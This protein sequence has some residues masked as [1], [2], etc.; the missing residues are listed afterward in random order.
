MTQTMTCPP[1]PRRRPG[2]LTFEAFL[3]MDEPE[4]AEWVDGRL[5]EMPGVTLEHAETTR[6][7][8]GLM[9]GLAEREEAGQVHADPFLMKLPDGRPGR[10]PDIIFIAR[11]HLDRLM[12]NHLA[13]PADVAVEVIS[14]GSRTIDRG[15]KYYEYEAGGVSEYWL[16]D[17]ERLVAEFYRLD[18]NGRYQP[19]ATPGGIF[20][21]EA[22]P[23]FW[24]RVEWLWTRPPLRLVE[25]ELAAGSG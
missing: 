18:P 5:V 4:R 14:P 3:A 10:A 21:S 23:G 9:W 19:V 2:Y 11:R 1:K 13:G 15:E 6:F 7:V 17:P 22:F 25:A 8:F 20:R 12:G 16:I 24:L